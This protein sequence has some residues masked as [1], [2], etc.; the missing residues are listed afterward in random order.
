M[1]RSFARVQN[2]QFMQGGKCDEFLYFTRA[3]DAA[4]YEAE[5]EE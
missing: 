4:L 5:D 1:M 3:V 2:G